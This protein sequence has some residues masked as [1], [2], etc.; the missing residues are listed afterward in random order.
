VNTIRDILGKRPECETGLLRLDPPSGYT[1][2]LFRRPSKVCEATE[3]IVCYYCGDTVILALDT[4][5]PAERYACP[6][7]G[8]RYALEEPTYEL[9]EC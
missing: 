1:Y 9:E 3:M 5:F 2:H 7:C 4:R 6:E 8:A